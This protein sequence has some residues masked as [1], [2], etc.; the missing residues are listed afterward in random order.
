MTEQELCEI[1][2]R[3]RTFKSELSHLRSLP[4]FEFLPP[5]KFLHINHSSK[6]LRE[7][8]L[9]QSKFTHTTLDFVKVLAAPYF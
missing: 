4:R 6:S 9:K 5:E 3:W 1:Q 8:F 7:P 2:R